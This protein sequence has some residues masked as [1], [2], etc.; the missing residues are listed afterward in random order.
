MRAV[1]SKS[2][3]IQIVVTSSSCG[4]A[5]L[6][7]VL[8]GVH[9]CTR[10]CVY[11]HNP[12]LSSQEDGSIMILLLQLRKLRHREG[13][14]VSKVVLLGKW[15]QSGFLSRVSLTPQLCSQA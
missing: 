15:W 8:C 9:V 14:P 1:S 11:A 2:L 12:M 10:A 13:L 7:E 3:T 6:S 5:T 4:P